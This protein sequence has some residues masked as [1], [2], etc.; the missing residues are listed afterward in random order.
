M[1][2]DA[3]RQRMRSRVLSMLRNNGDRLFRPK[4][5]SKRLDIQRRSDYELFQQV[6]DALVSEGLAARVKGGRVGYRKRSARVEGVLSVRPQGYGFVR[7]PGED[8]EYYVHQRRMGA[9]LDGD[10]VVV[11]LDA[12]SRDDRRREAEVIQ[13]VKRGRAQTVGTYRSRGR[14]G[15]V[16]PDDRRLTRDIYVTESA[17]ARDGDKVLVAIDRFDDARGA[18]EGRVLRVIGP[19]DDPAIRTLA[20]AMSMGIDADFP[21]DALAEAEAHPRKLDR[22]AIEGRLDLRREAIFTIDP[23]DA[24]DFDDA[25]HWK[26]LPEG[27]CEVGVHI[28]DVSHFVRPDSALDEAA[29]ERGTSVYLVDRVI[30]MLPERLSADLCSLRPDEERLAFS[31]IMTLDA[32][33][34]VLDYRITES[35]IRSRARLTYEEAQ[36]ILDDPGRAGSADPDVVAALRALARLAD[37][38][39]RRRMDH[40]AIDFD[41]PEVRVVLDE[42]GIVTEV[43]RKVR[44]GTHRLIEE[45]MLLANRTVA[46]HADRRHPDAAFVYRVHDRPNTERMGQLVSF[47]RAFGYKVTSQGGKIS[48]QELN[49]LLDEARGRPE[50][51]VIEEAALRAMAKAVYSPENVGH[52]GLAFT[53]YTHFTS[54]IRRY[55]DLMVHRLLK[56]LAAGRPTPD[57][58]DL[59]AACDHA[60]ERERAAD[61]AQRESVKLKQV[62]YMQQ[63][64]GD[65]FTGV[66]S[67][68][69]RFGVFVELDALLVEG[70]IHVRELSDDYYEYD[71]TT[72]SLTGR[73]NG[74]TFRLG[75]PLDII[76]A[77]ANTETREID[78]VLPGA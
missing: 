10:T 75:D 54:P 11:A 65:R 32:E 29:F 13:V 34:T 39:R 78:F 12:P 20:L 2:N 41:L 38:V 31:C 46:S 58:G 1:A 74:R 4:D 8:E 24:K 68:V 25:L 76:V 36:E 66:V 67:G 53:H 21:A 56:D 15:T 28:A 52:F 43:V 16:D 27:R 14:F 60:S 51:P 35:V 6:L 47:V 3:D 26:E 9:A 55:P 18:P 23:V 61:D 44:L 69:T 59:K 72:F 49:R 42:A 57:F 45:F 70:L 73:Y 7:V 17:D 64:V 50:E 40:G 19:S 33:G 62:E 48:S 63:H 77:A 71:E 5:L 22:A 30:P 37:I